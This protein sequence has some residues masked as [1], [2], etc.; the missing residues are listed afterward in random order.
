MAR[1]EVSFSLPA[2]RAKRQVR[3]IRHIGGGRLY[4]RDSPTKARRIRDKYL[5]RKNIQTTR[6]LGSEKELPAIYALPTTVVKPSVLYS[7]RL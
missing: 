3:Y 4:L 1:Y 5:R 6:R 2:L 7:L